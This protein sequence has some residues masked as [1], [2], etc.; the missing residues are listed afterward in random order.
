M[1]KNE[2]IAG[3]TF[4]LLDKTSGEA[5]TTGTP[6]GYVTLDA[7]SQAELDGA[8][9]HKGN[10]EWSVD[11]T[12]AETNADMIGLTF[13]H[14]DAVPVHFTINTTVPAAGAGAVPWPYTLTDST[15]GLPLTDAAAY[16]AA[17]TNTDTPPNIRFKAWFPSY[18]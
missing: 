6:A 2:A 5:I 15:T 11:L 18:V 13:T 4:L 14:A 12:A 17:L 1:I 7:G 16:P 10:G 3:L 9:T 8:I